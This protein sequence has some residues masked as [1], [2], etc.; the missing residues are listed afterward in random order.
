MKPP[1]IRPFDQFNSPARSR[2]QDCLRLDSVMHLPQ[3]TSGSSSSRGGN[4]DAF[5]FGFYG[6]LNFLPVAV[7]ILAEIELSFVQTAN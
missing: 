1:G 4:V 6:L 7:F 5:L 2:P 3:T